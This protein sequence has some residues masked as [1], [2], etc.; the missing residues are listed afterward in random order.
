MVKGSE[1]VKP[2]KDVPFVGFDQKILPTPAGPQI[3]KFCITKTDF[4]QN[5]H[6]SWRKCYK[7]RSRIGNSP[8]DLKFGVYNLTGNR[9]LAVS[10]HTQ[11]KIS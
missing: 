4:A 9:I 1:R 6:K 7:I 5:T 11:Q 3:P 2:P 10:A 8:K